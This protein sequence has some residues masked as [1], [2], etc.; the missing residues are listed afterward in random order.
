MSIE[1]FTLAEVRAVRLKKWIRSLEKKKVVCIQLA[2]PVA[3]IP[4]CTEVLCALR[5]AGISVL[6]LISAED[7]LLEDEELQG[8]FY[9]LRNWDQLLLR[10]FLETCGDWVPQEH[11]AVL[12]QES[13]TEF[14]WFQEWQ[15][16]LADPRVHKYPGL[17]WRSFLRKVN[18]ENFRFAEDFLRMVALNAS[19]ENRAA[20]DARIRS[21]L[22]A[23]K[24]VI[25][26]FPKKWS[27]KVTSRPVEVSP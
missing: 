13:R 27:S 22:E 24:K 4:E 7:S 16:A 17:P 15:T 14:K 21:F 2:A 10:N 11:L 18:S 20:L 26:V 19:D 12:S 1:Q 5:A 9:W 3:A 25:C 23:K 8:V 6:L